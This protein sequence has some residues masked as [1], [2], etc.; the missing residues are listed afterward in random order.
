MSYSLEIS[1]QTTDLDRLENDIEDGDDQANADK[2][3]ELNC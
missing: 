3:V 2:P 1:L